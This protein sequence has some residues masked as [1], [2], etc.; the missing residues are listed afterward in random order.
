MKIRRNPAQGRSIDVEFDG[1]ESYNYDDDD[2]SNGKSGKDTSCCSY[3][4]LFIFFICGIYGIFT[5]LNDIPAPVKIP[6][7]RS[8]IIN[9]PLHIEPIDARASSAASLGTTVQI[10]P[11][12]PGPFIK[13]DSEQV[14]HKDPEPKKVQERAALRAQPTPPLAVVD[15]NTPSLV[16]SKSI[17]LGELY[18]NLLLQIDEIRKMKQQGTVMEEDATAK[19]KIKEM[20]VTCRQYLKLRYG[21][22]PYYFVIEL[23]FPK[24]MPDYNSEGSFGILPI[25]LA[26]I[27]LV[28]Y[29]V[30]YMMDSVDNW[31]GGSFHRKAGHVLQAQVKLRKPSLAF[32][33]YHP[34]WPHRK[35]SL[36][37]CGR[38]GGPCYY[39]NT[40][41]NVQNHGPASQGS[42]TEA[43]S[44]FGKL[45]DFNGTDIEQLVKRMNKQPGAGQMGFINSP[46]DYIKTPKILFK[47]WE[48]YLNNKV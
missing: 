37:Y 14:D 25:Q 40:V 31:Q 36:G 28:P 39:I 44:N 42:R 30:F 7:V 38:P 16:T 35:Y 9:N 26:P 13:L 47:S 41:N 4:T 17:D 23:Q 48:N 24:S 27:D 3:V 19:Q 5:L 29:S 6:L 46:D 34:D 22:E 8:A 2:D 12:Q 10:K 11:N 15:T 32:Q 20:Q 21:P 18:N 45:I 43:D 33:E 1:T